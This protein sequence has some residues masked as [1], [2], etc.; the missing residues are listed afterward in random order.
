MYPVKLN[1]ANLVCVCPAEQTP[2]VPM[3]AQGGGAEPNAGCG[4]VKGNRGARE[5]GCHVPEKG[6]GPKRFEHL[7]WV[8]L[9]RAFPTLNLV[10]QINDTPKA[11]DTGSLPLGAP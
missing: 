10:K 11:E 7:T 5:S 2:W 8:G 4:R 9:S 6:K 3:Q 1:P